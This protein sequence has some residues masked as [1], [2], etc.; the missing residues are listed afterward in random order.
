MTELTTA[1]ISFKPTREE[2][3]VLPTEKLADLLSEI[4]S[5]ANWLL[6]SSGDRAEIIR[7]MNGG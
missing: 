5:G 6:L 3:S 1:I 7:E 2:D 4:V